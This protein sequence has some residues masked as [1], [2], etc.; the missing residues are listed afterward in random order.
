MAKQKRA[1]EKPSRSSLSRR[2]FLKTL[3]GGAVVT[4]L[5]GGIAVAGG[6]LPEG[7]ARD[8]AEVLGPGKV[9]IQLKVNGQERAVEVEP[10]ETLLD[11][12]RDRLD[13]TG[14]KE[15]CGMGECG[16]CTVLIDDVPHYSCLN[17][18]VQARGKSITTVEGLVQGDELGRVQKAFV[19]ADGLQCGYCTPGWIVSVEGL[20]RKHERPTEEQLRH[21]LSGNLCRCSAY[22]KILEA[23]KNVAGLGKKG[24]KSRGKEY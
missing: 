18:A 10:R 24:G 6:V 3:G 20:L 7:R 9:K 21:G 8:D 4:A 23:A 5:P 14:A 17:L 22:P 2:T 12:L 1:E 15:I 19:E 11:V 16:G 13:L